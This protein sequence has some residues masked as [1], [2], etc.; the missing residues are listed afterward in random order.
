MWDAIYTKADG[1]EIKLSGIGVTKIRDAFAQARK[2]AVCP[3]GKAISSICA[4]P[5]ESGS[6]TEAMYCDGK[7]YSATRV[8]VVFK[9]YTPTVSAPAGKA[10]GGHISGPKGFDGRGN[11]V[12]DG[13]EWLWK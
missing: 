13:P 6:W 7:L 12:Q 2:S 1:T 3:A 11:R 10:V 9:T 8:A 5:D 4:K